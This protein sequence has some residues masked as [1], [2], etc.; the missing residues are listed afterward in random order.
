MNDVVRRNINTEQARQVSKWGNQNHTPLRWLPILTEEV[1]EVAKAVNENDGEAY[2]AELVQ[3][4]A[5]ATSMI[6][7]YDRQMKEAEED[8]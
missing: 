3:V 8:G 2:R 1:G 5:V 4:A 7:C 6:E